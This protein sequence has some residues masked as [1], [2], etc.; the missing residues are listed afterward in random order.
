MPKRR[1]TWRRIKANS[2]YPDMRTWR[3]LRPWKRHSLV[4]MVAGLVFILVG[5]SYILIP[6]TPER[7]KAL[8]VAIMW[9]PFPFWG[10]CFIFAG[11]MSIISSRWPPVSKT[12]GYMVLTGLSG[13]WSATFLASIIVA[14]A[15]WANIS[16][17]IA[18][19]LLAFLWWAISG[20]YNL[21][22]ARLIYGQSDKV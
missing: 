6:A 22:D 7:E 13:G 21:E 4:L 8:A 3:G 19:G 5:V 15:P 12:W 20:L 18:W 10:G 1:I 17:F 11:L 16:G 14:H 9:A 2:L